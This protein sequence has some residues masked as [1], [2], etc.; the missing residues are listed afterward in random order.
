MLS[1]SIVRFAKK[2][3]FRGFAEMKVYLKMTVESNRDDLSENNAVQILCDSYI[4]AIHKIRDENFDEI[5]EMMFQARRIYIY[6]S[7]QVQNSIAKEL[8]R[9]FSNEGV[10]LY[11]LDHTVNYEALCKN[12]KQEDLVMIITLSGKSPETLKLAKFLNMQGIPFISI[13]KL[14]QNPVAMLSNASIF[15]QTS[16]YEIISKAIDSSSVLFLICEILA[17]KYQNFI[18]K[19]QEQ[20]VSAGETGDQE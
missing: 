5:F 14:Q 19:K 18:K 12:M 11:P 15:F 2:L 3:G 7:G 4:N 16:Q 8:Y 20:A 13:T 10:Y 6:G 17:L 9:L 1:A